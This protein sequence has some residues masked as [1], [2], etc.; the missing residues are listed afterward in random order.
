MRRT[1]PFVIPRNEMTRNPP[2]KGKRGDP[3]HAKARANGRALLRF[4]MTE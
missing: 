2:G 3:S 4:G 1:P